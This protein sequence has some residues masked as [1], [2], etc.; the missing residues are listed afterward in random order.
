MWSRLHHLLVNA[1]HTN[2]PKGTVAVTKRPELQARVLPAVV[3]LLSLQWVPGG[4]AVVFEFPRK[5]GFVSSCA[6]AQLPVNRPAVMSSFLFR[7]ATG[8]MAH[9]RTHRQGRA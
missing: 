7:R 3:P 5:C 2:T 8:N 6:A 9:T 4:C 1:A